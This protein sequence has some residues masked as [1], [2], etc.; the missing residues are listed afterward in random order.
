[1]LLI[2]LPEIE[3]VL[4]ILLDLDVFG[5]TGKEAF[6]FSIDDRSG[7]ALCQGKN[8]NNQRNDIPQRLFHKR[9]K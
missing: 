1:M 8:K 4:R 7:A 3:L 5:S 9:G 2:T 6:A